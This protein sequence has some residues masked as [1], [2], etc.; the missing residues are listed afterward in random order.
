MNNNQARRYILMG[1]IIRATMK[2]GGQPINR[3][4]CPNIRFTPELEYLIKH[5]HVQL[6]RKAISSRTTYTYA[7]ALPQ[8]AAEYLYLF[9]CPLCK[10]ELE[11]WYDMGGPRHKQS[12]ILHNG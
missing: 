11:G 2:W 5:K 10:V 6:T 12:C 9:R 4:Y 1:A 3:T 7:L 8:T